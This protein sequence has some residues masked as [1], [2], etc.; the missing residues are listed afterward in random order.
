MVTEAPTIPVAAAK[1]VE[2]NNTA[3]Y[4]A[5]WV[6]Y[7]HESSML[8]TDAPVTVVDAS[9]TLRGDGFRYYVDERRFELLGNVTV[10]QEP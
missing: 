4:S 2:T 6:R 7:N 5:P 1:M 3:I 9:G 10:D 8:V